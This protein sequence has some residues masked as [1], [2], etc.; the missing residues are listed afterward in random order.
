MFERKISAS[1][2]SSEKYLSSTSTNQGGWLLR[3]WL[4][5]FAQCVGLALASLTS[6]T[7]TTPTNEV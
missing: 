4:L 7:P 2:M 3:D 6:V 1:C 5:G